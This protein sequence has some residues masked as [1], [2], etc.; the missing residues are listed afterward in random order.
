MTTT[1]ESILTQGRYLL[2]SS[3]DTVAQL[4]SFDGDSNTLVAMD[5]CAL[6]LI[7]GDP[8]DFIGSIMPMEP[9]K[10]TGL[11]E[12]QATEFR[13]VSIKFRCNEGK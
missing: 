4:V 1:K 3:V 12:A 5:N 6:N 13:T 2:H 9:V 10:V 11:G 7:F 8:H